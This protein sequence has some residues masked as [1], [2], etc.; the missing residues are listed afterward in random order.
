LAGHLYLYGFGPFS[1]KL[2]VES[3]AG[4]FQGAQGTITFTASSGPSV[5]AAEFGVAPSPFA[6]TGNAFYLLQGTIDQGASQ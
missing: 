3:G 5:V 4:K 2:T 1:G 6:W